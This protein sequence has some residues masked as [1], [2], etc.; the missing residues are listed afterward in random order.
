MINGSNILTYIKFLYQKKYEKVAP[1]QLLSQWRSVPEHQIQ[2]ELQKLYAHWQWSVQQGR[3]E[4]EAFIQLTQLV[5]EQQEVKKTEV[6][7]QPIITEQPK[8]KRNWLA[9]FS[10]LLLLAIAYG[11][12]TNYESNKEVE[13]TQEKTG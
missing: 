11:I 6:V 2:S 12:Y 3:K 8:R 10:P 1:A 5:A 7:Q 4:E 13:T 9:W